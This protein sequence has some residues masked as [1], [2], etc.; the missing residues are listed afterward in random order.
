MTARS[1][2]TTR[3]PRNTTGPDG[4]AA[5]RGLTPAAFA[6]AAATPRVWVLSSPRAGER[7]QLLALAEALGCPFEVKR[8]AHQRLGSLVEVAATLMPDSDLVVGRP[9]VRRQV[10]GRQVESQLLRYLILDALRCQEASAL[11]GR[12][13]PLCIEMRR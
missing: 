13:L 11:A 12:F 3:T 4:L 6:P 9:P 7:S 8:I 10:L 5:V 2:A 1:F